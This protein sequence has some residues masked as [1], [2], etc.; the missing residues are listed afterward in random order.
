VRHAPARPGEL[1]RSAVDATKA[2]KD[3]GWRPTMTLSDG[4]RQTYEWIAEE[5]A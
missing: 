1:Q 2:G 5:A 4:L 3:L